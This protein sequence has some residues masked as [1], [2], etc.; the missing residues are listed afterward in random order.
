MY[1]LLMLG[2]LREIFL[3][4]IFGNIYADIGS[5]DIHDIDL[6]GTLQKT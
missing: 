2:Q 6:L 3:G 4:I 1:L 5:F